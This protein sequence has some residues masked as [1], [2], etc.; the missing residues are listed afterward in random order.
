VHGIGIYSAGMGPKGFALERFFD[1]KKIKKI[2]IKKK[3]TLSYNGMVFTKQPLRL[4]FSKLPKSFSHLPV[5]HRHHL[6][7]QCLLGKQ[8]GI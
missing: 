4:D 8:K 2:K 3:K 6:H 5:T 1:I 7:L